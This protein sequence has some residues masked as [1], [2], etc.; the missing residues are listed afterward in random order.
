MIVLGVTGGPPTAESYLG[1]FVQPGNSFNPAKVDDAD[2]LA[3]ANKMLT[4]RDNTERLKAVQDIQRYLAGKLHVVPVPAPVP[5]WLIQPWVKNYCYS[6]NTSLGT[7]T[8][9]KLWIGK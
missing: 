7:G 2:G 3:M 8:S 6:G 5:Q 9:A 4:I 1:S